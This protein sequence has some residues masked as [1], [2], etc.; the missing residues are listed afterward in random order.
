MRLR[1]PQ[2]DHGGVVH[3][4]AHVET[5][6][7]KSGSS[8][9]KPRTQERLGH[10]ARTSGGIRHHPYFEVGV[11]TAGSSIRI[12]GPRTVVPMLQRGQNSGVLQ[13][14]PCSGVISRS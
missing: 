10:R 7:T 11:S 12:Q 14:S 8:S 4:K 9:H 2:N 6:A 3:T 5:N 1:R 13:N